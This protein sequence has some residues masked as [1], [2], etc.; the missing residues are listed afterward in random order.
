MSDAQL[1]TDILLWLREN[2]R[3]HGNAK[4]R[5]TTLLPALCVLGHWPSPD[6]TAD[7]ALRKF[8]E[9]MPEVGSC[10]RGYFLIVTSEDRRIAQGNLHSRAMSELVHKKRIGDAGA[11]GQMGLFE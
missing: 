7:R 10:S 4:P 1:R 9:T 8:K 6:D 3:G 5:K 2:A 11:E